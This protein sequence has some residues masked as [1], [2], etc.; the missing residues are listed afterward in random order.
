MSMGMIPTDGVTEIRII[1][2]ASAP[3]DPALAKE[4]YRGQTTSAW[5]GWVQE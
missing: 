1:P 2:E 3:A 5:L 4:Q